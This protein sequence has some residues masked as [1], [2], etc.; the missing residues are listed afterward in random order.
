MKDLQTILETW[1]KWRAKDLHTKHKFVTATEY[2]KYKELKD[3][4]D[5]ECDLSTEEMHYSDGKPPATKPDVVFSEEF[6]NDGSVEREQTFSRTKRTK[7]SLHWSITESIK[8]GME[9][10][11]SASVPELV[12]VTEQ[13]SFEIGLSSTQAID[14]SSEEEWTVSTRIPVP[15]R[16]VTTAEMVIDTEKFE[17]PFQQDAVLTG[18]VAIWFEDKVKM[19]SGKDKHNLF[20]K[21]IDSVFREVVMNRLIDTAGYSI[22]GNGAV[23]ATASGTLTANQNVRCRT[24]VHDRPYG[25]PRPPRSADQRTIEETDQPATSTAYR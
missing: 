19:G 22:R 13:Q 14:Y 6:A 9:I 25:T 16:T 23:A 8:F 24:D 3:Y 11:A 20:F 7:S 17:L 18:D 1:A 5:R 4:R 15:P 21:P 2:G 10:T 12:S